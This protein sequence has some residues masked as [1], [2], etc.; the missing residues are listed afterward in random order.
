MY[1]E[2]QRVTMD[3]QGKAQIRPKKTL[4]IHFRLI[5]LV[6][7]ERERN[8]AITKGKSR[9][10]RSFYSLVFIRWESNCRFE[11]DEKNPVEKWKIWLLK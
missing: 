10:K 9:I 2:N 11:S 3:A 6:V 1:G 5:D 7:K 4:S 8:W